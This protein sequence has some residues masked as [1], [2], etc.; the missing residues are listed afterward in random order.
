M[1]INAAM[2]GPVNRGGMMSFCMAIFATLVLKPFNR[3]AMGFIITAVVGLSLLG[4]TG[5]SF[6][7]PGSDRDI[8]FMQLMSNVTSIFD[9]NAGNLEELQGTKEWRLNFWND[10]ID[11]TV[12][13]PMF[14]GGNGFGVNLVSHYNYQIDAEETVRAPHNGHITMLA[15]T[16]V[17]G[18]CL[19]V[20]TH[21]IWAGG[22]LDCY[23]RSRWEGKSRWAGLFM[24]LLIYWMLI[25]INACFDPYIEGPMGGVWLWSVWGVGLAAMYLRKTDPE[26]FEDEPVEHEQWWPGGLLQADEYSR[27]A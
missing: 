12:H 3:W 22:I 4:V 11:D 27:R 18:F 26:L 23:I 21:L 17:P 20:L 16:G 25:M 8:S 19:W 24:F 14:W 2:L 13:G 10:I 7:I 9:K 1:F 15:R 5:F 6:R